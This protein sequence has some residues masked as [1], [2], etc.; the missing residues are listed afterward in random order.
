MKVLVQLGLI[1][2]LMGMVFSC[3]KDFVYDDLCHDNDEKVISPWDKDK[4]TTSVEEK[5]DSTVGAFDV[6]L[7]RWRDTI[8]TNINL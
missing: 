3:E 8:V 6:T 4:D 7:D 2:C 5:R 1:I